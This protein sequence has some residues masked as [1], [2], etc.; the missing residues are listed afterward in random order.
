MSV[1]EP[2]RPPTAAQRGLE[3]RGQRLALAGM[4][5]NILLA[6]VKLVAGIVGHSYALIADAIE[7]IA[8]IVGSLVIWS[9]LRVASRPSDQRHPYGYGK[10]ESLA[11][12]MVA[13]MILVAGIA[14][15][16]EAIRE[17]LTPHHAPA[18]FTLAVLIAVVITK[19]IM[20]R[21]VRRAASD[22]GSTA[23]ETDS[24][25]HRADAITSIAAFVGITIALVGGKGYEPADDWAALVASAVIGFNAIKLMIPPV[26]ELLDAQAGDVGE[27]ASMIAAAIPGIENVQKAVARKAGS[28]YWVDMHARVAA[29][30]TV[31]DAHTLAHRVK[32]AVR[33]QMPEVRDVLIHIEPSSIPAGV[34]TATARSA[35]RDEMT[36]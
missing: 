10:A 33:A 8:D 2:S 21:V 3:S 12:F 14:I 7:S 22:S 11:S 26:R 19:E 25:H 34:Q 18:A 36:D 15:A 27:R 1:P 20:F 4:V 28:G 23:L 6:I 31:Y 17:I 30:M 13:L 35:G 16:V 32:D 24:W 9:G 29:E 5:V